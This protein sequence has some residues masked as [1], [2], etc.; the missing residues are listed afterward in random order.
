MIGQHLAD[1]VLHSAVGGASVRRRRGMRHHELRHCTDELGC[2][3]RRQLMQDLRSS[4]VSHRLYACS[5][6]L[7]VHR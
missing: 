1:D 2:V 6:G 3:V 5:E 4:E 7:L